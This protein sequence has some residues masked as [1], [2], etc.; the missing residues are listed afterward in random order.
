[1]QYYQFIP[2]FILSHFVCSQI[3][4]NLLTIK[5]GWLI[6]WWYLRKKWHS[7]C[8]WQWALKFGTLIC[9]II[10]IKT[11]L[12]ESYNLDKCANWQQWFSNS[13][14]ITIDWIYK[15]INTFQ[16]R[17]SFYFVKCKRWHFAKVTFDKYLRR[18]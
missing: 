5:Y 15:W 7:K 2:Q 6:L 11:N 4:I 18:C 17:I 10:F 12:K 9:K 13:H 14:Q 16:T 3:I 8:F 1:M